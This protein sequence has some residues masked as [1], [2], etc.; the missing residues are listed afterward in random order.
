[1][2]AEFNKWLELVSK[3]SQVLFVE[4]DVHFVEMVTRIAAQYNCEI[5]QV[6]TVPDAVL[7]IVHRSFDLIILDSKLPGV[8]GLEL[9]KHIHRLQIEV[10][11]VLLSGYI[12]TEMIL[13]AQRLGLVAFIAKPVDDVIEQL[14]KIFRVLGIRA[15][16]PKK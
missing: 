9:L 4:D 8:N 15:R 1:M 6:G 12:T 3:P 2:D 13:D 14:D 7:Q 16:S 11:V 10:P 5:E